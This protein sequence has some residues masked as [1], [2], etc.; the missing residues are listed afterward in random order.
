M[1]KRAAQTGL[2][3]P[4]MFVENDN[5]GHT[6]NFYVSIHIFALMLKACMICTFYQRGMVPTAHE[7][8]LYWE[9][10]LTGQFPF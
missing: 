1:G 2:L 10:G 6:Y 9:L 8:V 4:W 5:A 7:H 3:L